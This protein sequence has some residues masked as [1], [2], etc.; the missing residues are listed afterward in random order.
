MSLIGELFSFVV[1]ATSPPPPPLGKSFPF[2]NQ[3]H[4]TT[5]FF[6]PIIK[7]VIVECWKKKG[8]P[9]V[10][11]IPKVI[12]Y[13]QNIAPLFFCTKT[14]KNSR[15]Q[16]TWPSFHFRPTHWPTFIPSLSL[17]LSISPTHT[18]RF[19]YPFLSAQ[20]LRHRQE[21]KTTAA[22]GETFTIL[23]HRLLAVH[24]NMITHN[25]VNPIMFIFLFRDD[26]DL[27][28]YAVTKQRTL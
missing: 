22:V 17:S 16:T 13:V 28:R 18:H 4:N 8:Q 11:L 24:K 26:R 20:L 25:S 3:Q 5:L 14:E 27:T 1:V 15:L 6:W 12:F 9:T 23:Q 10:S 19:S 2:T 21:Q 7:C